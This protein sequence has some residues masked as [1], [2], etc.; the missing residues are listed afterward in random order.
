LA[1]LQ[2]LLVLLAL[3]LVPLHP[4]VELHQVPPCFL[5]TLA[6]ASRDRD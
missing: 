2:L 5:K 3:R 4:F 1:S 6:V